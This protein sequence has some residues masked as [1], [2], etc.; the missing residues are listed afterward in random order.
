MCGIFGH[1][2]L[3]KRKKFNFSLFATLGINNDIRGGDSCGIF[4]D[5]KSEYG[6]SISNKYFS[7]FFLDSTILRET[8]EFNIAIG[9]CRKASPGMG[10]DP[11]KAQPVVLKNPKTE[12][13]RFVMIHNG[14]IYNYKELAKKYIPNVDINGLS[15]SQVM[16]RIF[17]YKGYDCLS[18]YYGGSVFFIVDY[19]QPKPQVL[20]FKGVS[21]KTNFQTS[22]ITEERP[23]YISLGK[24]DLVFSSIDSFLPAFRPK[25][26]VK[27]IPGNTLLQY[28]EGKLW[29]VK[30]Y[31][32]SSV[33]QQKQLPVI[34]CEENY[35]GNITVKS[36]SRTYIIYDENKNIYKSSEIPVH[37]LKHVE[38]YG[39]CEKEPTK[40]TKEYWFFHGIPLKDKECFKFL[41][42]YQK[43]TKKNTDE[44][45]KKYQNLIRLLSIDRLYFKNGLL[46]ISTSVINYKVYTGKVRNLFGS[47]IFT[48]YK[49]KFISREYDKESNE[50]ELKTLLDS[51][52]IYDIT[53]LRKK[54]C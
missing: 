27:T 33:S 12:E 19:R 40:K 49:G 31:D 2:S 52:N 37:G 11:E 8:K 24:D 21:K 53:K 51:K 44:F 7:D 29:E 46:V 45:V 17:F 38:R 15:D 23:L 4:I 5:G 32:R 1:I 50:I 47:N 18:E 41:E 22:Q 48:Y 10:L 30:K 43:K 13:T 36:F 3:E 34:T 35:W 54:L 14:T 39:F 20:L 42:E 28:K 26:E 6:T 25:I 9:H 16:A